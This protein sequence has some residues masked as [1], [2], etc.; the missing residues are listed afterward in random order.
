MSHFNFYYTTTSNGKK[1]HKVYSRKIDDPAIN[2]NGD[3]TVSW[4]DHIENSKL[5]G[6]VVQKYKIVEWTYNQSKEECDSEKESLNEKFK[7]AGSDKIPSY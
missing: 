5:T 6:G 1:F 7:Y 3:G 2:F 4:K